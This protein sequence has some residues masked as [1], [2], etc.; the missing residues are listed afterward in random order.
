ME[1]YQ[2]IFKEQKK[3]TGSLKQE[4]TT[5]GSQLQLPK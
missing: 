1:T 5:P 4:T 2:E 3:E